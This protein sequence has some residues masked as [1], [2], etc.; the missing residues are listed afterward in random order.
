[1]RQKHRNDQNHGKNGHV[2]GNP[3]YNGEGSLG[4]SHP[5]RFRRYDERQAAEV[6]Q[7]SVDFG[8]GDNDLPNNGH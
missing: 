3:R 1:M 6:L 5:S 7:E 8:Y 4:G 2:A